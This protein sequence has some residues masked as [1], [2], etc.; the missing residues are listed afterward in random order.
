MPIIYFCAFTVAQFA[1]LCKCCPCVCI[2]HFSQRLGRKSATTLKIVPLIPIKLQSNPRQS[3]TVIDLVL[4][5]N[6]PTLRNRLAERHHIQSSIALA[7]TSLLLDGGAVQARIPVGGEDEVCVLGRTGELDGIAVVRIEGG[8]N[9]LVDD[10][11]GGLNDVSVFKAEV[12]VVTGVGLFE[13][14]LFGIGWRLQKVGGHKIGDGLLYE[15]IV[16]THV[17][18]F[19][20]AFLGVRF[21][22][23]PFKVQPLYSSKTLV[24]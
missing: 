5:C 23:T 13:S 7:M 15:S 3:T 20:L 19:V 12:D 24:V 11:F 22:L 14:G 4:V 2:D 18:F 8:E 21:C 16:C 9:F 10:T 1:S 17:V 6:P